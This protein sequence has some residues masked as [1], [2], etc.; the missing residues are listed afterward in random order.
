[1]QYYLVAITKELTPEVGQL[2]GNILVGE[3]KQM[4]YVP[5]NVKFSHQYNID[6]LEWQCVA[7]CDVEWSVELI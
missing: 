5:S 4:G 2:C 1:M 6:C 3:C 7:H